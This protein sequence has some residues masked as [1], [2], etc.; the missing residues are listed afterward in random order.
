MEDFIALPI[1]QKN[2]VQMLPLPLVLTLVFFTRVGSSWRRQKTTC[3]SIVC[4]YK[5]VSHLFCTNNILITHDTLS[6]C[7]PGTF[8]T[9]WIPL[10]P[11]KTGSSSNASGKLNTWV[12]WILVSFVGLL[13][14]SR[15]ELGRPRPWQRHLPR[16]S[17][18]HLQGTPQGQS[19]DWQ[20][21]HQGQPWEQFVNLSQ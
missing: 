4:H 20:P 2:F 10:V 5:N 11:P 18:Y 6:Q 1:P 16:T 19:R 7:P 21:H 15:A 13:A 17:G 14:P 9:P 8:D 3:G 12:S